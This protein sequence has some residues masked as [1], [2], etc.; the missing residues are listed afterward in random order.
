MQ[1]WQTSDV[2]RASGLPEVDLIRDPARI[3]R[4]RQLVPSVAG[5][6]VLS[7]LVRLA[8]LGVEA[9]CGQLSLLAEQQVATAVRCADGGYA[10]QSSAIED[11]LC[12]VTVLSGDVLVVADAR[13]HPWLHDLAPVLSGAVVAYLG[14]PLR[15][16]DGT[17]VGALCVYGPSPRAWTDR[18]V[19]LTCEVA[20]VVALE[21]ERLAQA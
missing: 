17:A 1:P 19:G 12:S 16:A 8:A 14:V 5:S 18:D 20:D 6:A 13:A 7:R 10:E 15:L 11:S 4:V 2:R 9:E 21:L 3:A